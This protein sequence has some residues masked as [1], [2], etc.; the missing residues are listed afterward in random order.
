MIP[1]VVFIGHEARE[2]DA[3]EVCEASMRK[4]ASIPLQMHRLSEP[5]LRHI[6]LYHRQWR[7]AGNQRVDVG[8]G[9]PFSTAF[10][11]TRFLV[12]SLM[13]HSGWAL[14]CDSDFLWRDDVLRIFSQMDPSKAVF[15]VRHGPLDASGT[16]MDGQAQQP[17]YRKNWSSLILWNAGH[18]SN[19]RLVPHVVNKMPGQWL[20]AFSWLDDDQIGGLDPRWNYLVGVDKITADA[21]AAHF[22]MGIP[23]MPGHEHD[24]L[25]DEWRS[26]LR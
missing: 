20:H 9:K 10:S 6:G 26:Y 2:P 16:K 19:Q 25:A 7:M 23:L 3:T 5:A 4:H 14:F 21:R 13:Q 15:V 1:Q 8:D 24:H 18:P 12:P 17:Y 11:F 22:T